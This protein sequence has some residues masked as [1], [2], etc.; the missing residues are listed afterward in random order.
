[1]NK[2]ICPLRDICRE[3]WKDFTYDLDKDCLM[4]KALTEVK[5]EVIEFIK[6]KIYDREGFFFEGEVLDKEKGLE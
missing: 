3:S 4:R 2:E 6:R 5:P 1:M